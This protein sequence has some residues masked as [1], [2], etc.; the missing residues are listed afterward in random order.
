MKCESK[1]FAGFCGIENQVAAGTAG[2]LRSGMNET[3]VRNENES[4]SRENLFAFFGAAADTRRAKPASCSTDARACRWN[5]MDM[6]TEASKARESRKAFQSNRSAHKLL[7]LVN[8]ILV[9]VALSTKAM[10]F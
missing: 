6:E 1:K 8:A 4:I 3:L 5:D 2:A 7:L 9:L 10:D